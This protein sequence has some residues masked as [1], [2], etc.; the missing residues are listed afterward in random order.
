[1]I[2][3]VGLLGPGQEEMSRFAWKA[4]AQWEMRLDGTKEEKAKKAEMLKYLIAFRDTFSRPVKR[5]KFLGLFD[6]V[7]SVPQFESAW[8]QRSKFPYTARSSALT[9]RHAVAIDER[10]AKFRQDLLGEVK[11]GSSHGATVRRGRPLERSLEDHLGLPERDATPH[12]EGSEIS[13]RYKR[14]NHTNHRSL[15][16]QRSRVN[17]MSPARS[18]VAATDRSGLT[19]GS[20]ISIPLRRGTGGGGDDEDDDEDTPQD[21]Q[22]VW[23]PGAHAVCLVGMFSQGGRVPN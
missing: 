10:R 16:V 5:I 4:F 1:M 20:Q 18:S 19:A 15:S 6:T 3:G 21:I 9:I 23:F 17:S 8:L 12:R 2:D 13:E 22:E 14:P 11:Q 7:N